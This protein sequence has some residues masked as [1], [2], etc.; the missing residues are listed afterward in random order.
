MACD[1]LVASHADTTGMLTLFRAIGLPCGVPVASPADT[2]DHPKPAPSNRLGVRPFRHRTGGKL[3][4]SVTHGR[5]G[6]YDGRQFDDGYG[7]SSA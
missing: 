5:L 3:A 6:D 1:H 7:S 2:A 4:C